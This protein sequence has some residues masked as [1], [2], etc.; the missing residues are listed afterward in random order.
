MIVFLY[1][2]FY[3]TASADISTPRPIYSE[4]ELGDPR[5]PPY[6]SNPYLW[7]LPI[8]VVVVLY[9]F[10]RMRKKRSETVTSLSST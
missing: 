5:L 9:I 1:Y 7:L 2:I 3:N 10:S 4:I 6:S 8:G